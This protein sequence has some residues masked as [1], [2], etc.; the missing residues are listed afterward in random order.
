MDSSRHGTKHDD[1]VVPV[2]LDGRTDGNVFPTTTNFNDQSPISN[3][4]SNRLPPKPPLVKSSSVYRRRTSFAKQKSRLEEN[5]SISRSPSSYSSSFTS[6]ADDLRGESKRTSVRYNDEEDDEEMEVYQLD[7]SK[8]RKRRGLKIIVLMEWFILFLSGGFLV[9]SLTFPRLEGLEIWDLKVWKWCVVVVMV[10][11]ARL[12]TNCLV[13]ILV[14]LIERNFIF[15]KKVLYF[16]YGLKTSLQVCIWFGL[17]LVGWVMVLNQGASWSEKMTQV[18]HFLI[19][20]LI[21]SVIWLMKTL[22]VKLLASSF[23]VNRFFDRIQESVFNQYILQTL[24]GPPVVEIRKHLVFKKKKKEKKQEGRINVGKLNRMRR[25]KVNAW[26][27]KG[28]MS[29]IS[30]GFLTI[31]NEEEITNEAEAQTVGYQIFKNV[32]KP[33]TKY[34]EE[35]DLLRFLSRE[36]TDIVFPLF[37][38]AAET[39]KIKKKSV[40]RW[41]VNAYIE[42]KSLALSLSDTKTGVKQVHRLASSIVFVIILVI[43]LL[44]MGLATLEI[45]LLFSSHLVLVAFVFGNTCKTIFEAIIFVF[46]MHPFDVG[47]RCVID[48]VHMTV[49]EMNILNTVFLRYDN[50]KIYYPNAVLSTK[51]ISNFFR[52]PDMYDNIDFSVGFSTTVETIGV[53]KSRIKTYIESKPMYWYP[54]HNIV[55][56]TIHDVNKINMSL[57]FRHTITYQDIV[58]RIMRKTELIIELKNIFE[59][60]DIRYSLLP[61]HV[62]LKMAPSLSTS[63]L[64]PN[65]F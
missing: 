52:S 29:V 8:K 31:L 3:S 51:P 46:V 19:A 50:E 63:E 65:V 61:Q 11:C 14:F 53:L 26:T 43:T 64:L 15:K 36:E 48:G 40:V 59:D 44:L 4:P 39:G 9:G 23:H 54:T 5:M 12:F 28:L 17:M 62:N 10:F 16:V 13:F 34:I 7:F 56:N 45:L 35:D 30:S 6:G 42:R 2:S 55:I 60:L 41:V 37:K 38:G 20:C 21:G 25:E 47:D 27:M 32:A 33:Q 49:E 24:L 22:L 1:V 58:A 18:T 57:Y